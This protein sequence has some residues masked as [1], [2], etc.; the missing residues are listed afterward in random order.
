MNWESFRA[1]LSQQVLAEKDRGEFVDVAIALSDGQ[2][3]HCHKFILSVT[4]TFFHK[5]IRAIGHNYP[6]IYLHGIPPHEVLAILEFMYSGSVTVNKEN[7][8]SFLK[9]AETLGVKGLVSPNH[10]DISDA[11]SSQEWVD[12]N[13]FLAIKS[14]SVRSEV[15]N[16]SPF[17]QSAHL[18]KKKG[19]GG[20]RQR[21]DSNIKRP[22]RELLASEALD[23]HLDSFILKTDNPDKKWKCKKCGKSFKRKR[24]LVSH[25]ESHLKVQLK[26]NIC[27]YPAPTSNALREHQRIKHGKMGGNPIE[28]ED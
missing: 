3:L 22:K 19:V 4:S 16:S 2:I 28:D 7:L 26:C 27:S 25:I 14:N 12:P 18:E 17:F 8:R 6:L 5:T 21:M 1:N 23:E 15:S 20:E 10:G 11:Q 24:N 9:T 13:E